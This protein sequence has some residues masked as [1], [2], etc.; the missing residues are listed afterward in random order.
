[1]SVKEHVHFT[2]RFR[3]RQSYQYFVHIFVK[4]LLATDIGSILSSF[5]FHYLSNRLAIEHGLLSFWIWLR[6][7]FILPYHVFVDRCS[8][9]TSPCRLEDL[10]RNTQKF[11][12]KYE[13]SNKARLLKSNWKPWCLIQTLIQW[14]HSHVWI[15]NKLSIILPLTGAD[16]RWACPDLHQSSRSYWPAG[17]ERSG[18]T[19]PV[20]AAGDP[21]DGNSHFLCW[22]P[23]WIIARSWHW[24]LSISL[25]S[26]IRPVSV[27]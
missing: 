21:S 3:K 1:M 2:C 7:L 27:S 8:Q 22:W 9:T 6:N 24:Q 10:S 13:E 18:R 4:W 12:L 15:L 11:I 17:Q 14:L 23:V 19:A 20:I 5:P 16:R 26:F 25:K